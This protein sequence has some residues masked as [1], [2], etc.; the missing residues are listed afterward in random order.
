MIGC[1]A[2]V[3]GALYISDMVAQKR[4]RETVRVAESRHQTE[5]ENMRAAAGREHTRLVRDT[6]DVAATVDGRIVVNDGFYNMDENYAMVRYFRDKTCDEEM[7]NALE[8]INSVN[9]FDDYHEIRHAYNARFTIHCPDSTPDIIA[10]DELSARIA[11]HLARLGNMPPMQIGEISPRVSYRLGVNLYDVVDHI[12]MFELQRLYDNPKYFR[13]YVV[14]SQVRQKFDLR[15]P[16]INQ[17]ALI[18][19]MMT[20]EINGRPENILKYASDNV[21]AAVYEY[22]NRCNVR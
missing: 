2:A 17:D 14:Q 6:V 16:Q 19:E 8:Y 5:M 18:D 21:R 3:A 10:Y 12:L 15:N 11:A 20:F 4:A 13:D 7:R 22:V 1:G 9:K